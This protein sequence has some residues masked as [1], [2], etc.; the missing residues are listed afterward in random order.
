MY[1]SHLLHPSINGHLCGVHVL[2]VVNSAVTNTG[3]H[4]LLRIIVLSGYR[5]RSRIAGSY[6]D[7]IF[8]FLRRG[9]TPNVTSSLSPSL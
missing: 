8:I 2:A 5:P 3:V 1:V 6:G 9:K 7:S 4:V